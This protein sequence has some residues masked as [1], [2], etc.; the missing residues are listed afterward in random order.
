MKFT[1]TQE[2][3]IGGSNFKFSHVDIGSLGA[4]E[5]TLVGF[6]GDVSGSVSPYGPALELMLKEVVKS[7]RRSPRADNLQLRTILFNQNVTEVHGFKPL[8]SCNEDD[9]TG[10]IR[11]SGYT[12]LFDATYSMVKSMS[13]Y[14]EEL[15]K[16]DFAVN[17]VLFVL[18]DGQ[19]NESKTTAAMVKDAIKEARSKECLESIMPVL[20]GVGVGSDASSLDQYLQAFKNEAEFQQYIA[21]DKADEKTLA[22]LGGFISK[23]ISSQSQALGSGGASQSVT[24]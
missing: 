24:F 16:Q 22:K 8:P 9:Y 1:D 23:S 12:A 6:V 15:Q 7:C 3:T 13:Q 18:T 14:G 19:D 2:K 10:C 17:A 4:T 5:Y 21:L 11:P 20:I